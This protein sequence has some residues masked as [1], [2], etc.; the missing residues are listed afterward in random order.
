MQRHRF[1]VVIAHATGFGALQ[2]RY[3]L[4]S[5]RIRGGNPQVLAGQDRARPRAGNGGFGRKPE[6]L[7]QKS[8]IDPGPDEARDRDLGLHQVLDSRNRQRRIGNRPA[9][10]RHHQILML[11]HM[12]KARRQL[13]QQ[14]ILARPGK[15]NQGLVVLFKTDHRDG[16]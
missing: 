5:L 13:A 1:A 4:T 12:Q 7:I 11:I 9:E 16:V 6:H 15:R 8:Q 2:H 14:G 3:H 10:L